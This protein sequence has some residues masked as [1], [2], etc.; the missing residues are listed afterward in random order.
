VPD[1]EAI[2]PWRGWSDLLAMQA[3]CSRRLA[4]APGRTYAHP[5]DVAWWTK[6]QS[7]EALAATFLL[8]EI[9]GTVPGFAGVFEDE[10]AFTVLVDAAHRDTDRAVAFEEAIMA[11]AAARMPGPLRVSGLELETG[12]FAR[13]RDRGFAPID[14]GYR[15][16]VRPLDP[17]ADVEPDGVEVRAVTE[18]DLAM[19]AAVTYAAFDNDGPLDAYIDTYAAFWSSPASPRGWDLL[20]LTSDG[21]PAACC[22]AWP[23][24]ASG[25]GTFEPVATHPDHHRQGYGRAILRAGFARLA[26]AG[27]AWAIVGTNLTNDPAEGLYRSVGFEPDTVLRFLERP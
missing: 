11:I 19:R 4:A 15:N 10:R 2:R 14:V 22:I 25:A 6:G 7:D 17:T 1:A 23:D 26:A 21:A 9:D 16:F 20:A 5:G 13:W 8:W 18:D 24:R 27:M 12:A 3:V